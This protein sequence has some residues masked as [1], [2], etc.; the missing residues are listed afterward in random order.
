MVG[1][2]CAAVTSS[3]HCQSTCRSPMLFCYI[4]IVFINSIGLTDLNSRYFMSEAKVNP[5]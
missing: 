2:L 4:C 5:R 3:G 1:L